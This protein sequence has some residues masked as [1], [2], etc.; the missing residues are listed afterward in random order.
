MLA[1]GSG[2]L[3]SSVIVPFTLWENPKVITERNNPNT[4]DFITNSIKIDD[5]NVYP[6]FSF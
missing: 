3:V 2:R 6:P 4:S 5:V 1:N